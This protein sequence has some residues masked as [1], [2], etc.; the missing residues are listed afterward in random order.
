VT[1]A[2]LLRYL[3]ESLEE[4]GIE[5]MITGSQAS[6]YYGEPRYEWARRLALREIWEGVRQRGAEADKDGG[7]D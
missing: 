1:Q 2:E 5:Y 7:R 6:I 3:M 4:L